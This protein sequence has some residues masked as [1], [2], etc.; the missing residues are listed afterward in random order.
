MDP[1]AFQRFLSAGQA[2]FKACQM[3]DDP[4]RWEAAEE[5]R[6]SLRIWCGE[7][8]GVFFAKSRRVQ[9]PDHIGHISLADELAVFLQARHA[10]LYHRKADETFDPIA[11]FGRPAGAIAP[12]GPLIRWLI[13]HDAPLAR[14]QLSVGDLTPEDAEA[15]LEEVDALGAAVVV[16]LTTWLDGELKG[17]LVV[18][19]PLTG[20]YGQEEILRLCQHGQAIVSALRRRELGCPTVDEVKAEREA[21][22]LQTL[23]D[24]WPMLKPSPPIRCLILDELPETI[25]YLGA[26]FAMWDIPT[27]GYT[28]QQEALQALD[29]FPPDVAVVDLSLYQTTPLEFLKTLAS[30]FPKTLLFGMT[31]GCADTD[32][33]VAMEL[34][35]R[36]IF[37]KPCRIEPVVYEILEAILTQRLVAPASET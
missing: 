29:R 35:V 37:R 13:E 5:F 9:G 4:K 3:L 7:E 22:A 19:P 32:E 8:P 20:E 28:N 23:N 21:N 27:Q 34:G 26:H 31:T 1:Q 6:Q 11:T 12:H 24:W 17:V 36:R 2:S 25:E 18:G 15:L 33:S 14:A 16:P 10:C 30:R